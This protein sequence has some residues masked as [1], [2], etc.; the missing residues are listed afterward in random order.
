[1]R[2]R[3]A[4][5]LAFALLLFGCL[6]S[7]KESLKLATTTSTYD[8]GLLDYL[9]PEFEKQYGVEVKVIAVGTGQAIE[10][11]KRGDADVLLVHSPKDE[12]AFE[13]GGYSEGRH[14]VMYNDFVIAGPA[15][16]KA[17]I[18]GANATE[19]LR[20]MA[21]SGAAFVSRGDDSG[22]NK[23]EIELW[24]RA[25]ITPSGSWYIDAGAGM[26]DTLRIASERKAYVFSD[27]AT[28]AS[29]PALNLAVL[30]EGGGELLNPYGIMAVNATRFGTNG[31]L[32]G[33][34]VEFMMSEKGQALIGGYE[35]GGMQLF[36]PLGGKCIA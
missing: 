8:S 7:G 21:K 13:S 35:K 22:T 10:M 28:L 11:G 25:G 26:G 9:L 12:K 36:H 2:V 29:M 15:D 27:R 34:F 30:S 18:R 5:A 16:D 17:G 32:A 1:M 3:I 19:A 20:R 23:K 4:L 6:G 31:A 14:C 24:K 33:A